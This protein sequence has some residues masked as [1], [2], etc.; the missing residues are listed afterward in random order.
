MQHSVSSQQHPSNFNMMFHYGQA[1][2]NHQ[3]HFQPS[4]NGQLNLNSQNFMP[5]SMHKQH[6]SVP[7]GQNPFAML[8]KGTMSL[9]GDDRVKLMMA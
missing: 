2:P 8:E 9:A 4:S 5:N 1:A 6:A 3:Q 7:Q